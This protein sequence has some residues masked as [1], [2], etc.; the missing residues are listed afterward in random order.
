M[1]TEFRK[2]LTRFG[3]EWFN[4]YYGVYRGVVADNEDPEHM[5]RLKLVI[6]QVTGKETHEYWCDGVGNFAGASYGF[7]LL[8]EKGDTVWVMFENGDVQ[9]PLW[10][11]GRFKKEV[12]DKESYPKRRTL[13]LST[14]QCL[15]MDEDKMFVMLDN[16]GSH[17]LINGKGISLVRDGASIFLGDENTADQA[18]VLG[19]TMEAKI[20]ALHGHLETLRAELF[21]LLPAY[22]PAEPATIATVTATLTALQ[23]ELA[24]L[25]PTYKEIKSKT[26]FLDE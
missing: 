20:D 25:K 2:I 6:P 4:R 26:V 18:A 14:G 11:Q 7:L 1:L 10:M 16:N 22:V 15:V 19:E 3:L 23:I 21:K 5:G 12:F 13:Q 17:L 9:Y 24:T 8:P